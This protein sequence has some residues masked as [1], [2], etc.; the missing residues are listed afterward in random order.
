MGKKKDLNKRVR[1]TQKQIK[2]DD[3]KAAS[4]LKKNTRPI[5]MLLQKKQKQ[6]PK[7]QPKQQQ[8]AAAAKETAAP[9]RLRQSPRRNRKQ[10]GQQQ[11]QRPILID[12]NFRFRQDGSASFDAGVFGQLV[13]GEAPPPTVAQVPTPIF[14]WRVMIYDK[15]EDTPQCKMTIVQGRADDGDNDNNVLVDWYGNL[16]IDGMST[17]RV[18]MGTS[19]AFTVAGTSTG[20]SS[21]FRR[22]LQSGQET[23]LPIMSLFRRVTLN[24]QESSSI[25]SLHLLAFSR[26]KVTMQLAATLA[27]L[28]KQS[29]SKRRSRHHFSGLL[30]LSMSSS[31]RL[32]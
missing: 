15:D 5:K 25:S 17:A 11:Q 1:R 16:T 18:T 6:Q 12:S 13:T 2:E 27:R 4:A 19:P 32:A 28:K 8:Q 31:R 23:S 26:P 24:R 10:Q 29:K 14:D 22:R 30:N 7:Q 9:A 20:L 21:K 3:A